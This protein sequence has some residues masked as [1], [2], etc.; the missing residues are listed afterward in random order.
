MVHIGIIGT[1]S[2]S[3]R[4]ALAVQASP[5]ACLAAVCSTSQDRAD[6]FAARYG[7]EK[8]YGSLPD[9][10]A[11]PSVDAVIVTTLNSAHAFITIE[12]LGAGKHVLCEKPMAIN[13]HEAQRMVDAALGGNRL[14]MMGF[15]LRF[16]PAAT[17]MRQFID[18]GMVGPIHYGKVRILRRNG[19]PGGWFG[20]RE[21]SGGGSLIDL[22]VH[23]IDFARW[24]M[25]SP[26]PVS[27]YGATF[28]RPRGRAGVPQSKTGH[29]AA[30]AMDGDTCDVE[31][32][33]TAMIR[34]SGGSVLFVETAFCMDIP[35]E[36]DIS[37]ELFGECAGLRLRDTLE[38]FSQHGGHLTDTAVPLA[39]LGDSAHNFGNQLAHFVDAIEGAPCLSTALDGLWVQRILDAIYESART[40]HEVRM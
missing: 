27:V 24:M 23:A 14:L 2:I 18:D 31:D 22:G 6:S 37:I 4:H 11:D 10:L 8:A 40:G 19:F 29:A 16:S 39:T 15:T 32:L 7:I 13:R 25:G 20:R 9:L 5:K 33:A 34:F 1:G 38:V 3:H 36:E 26:D 12:A 28:D 21:L 35:E 17:A 30:G